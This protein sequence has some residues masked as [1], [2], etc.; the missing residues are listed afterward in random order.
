MPLSF[1]W[2]SL[3]KHWHYH[4]AQDLVPADS[5]LFEGT[6][7]HIYLLPVIYWLMA[8]QVVNDEFLRHVRKGA[9]KYVRGD[10]IRLTSSSVLVNVRPRGSK[11]GSKGEEKVRL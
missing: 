2:E 7:V 5:G 9:C 3:L 1:L 11:P 8:F 6:P 10:P 4:G